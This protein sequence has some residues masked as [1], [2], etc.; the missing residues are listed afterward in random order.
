MFDQL[1]NLE[2]F[3]FNV[4]A[5]PL[6]AVGMLIFI[7]GSSILWQGRKICKNVSFFLLCASF[8][9]WLCSMGI[10]YLCNNV[11]SALLWYK[12]FTFF[13]VVSIMPSGYLFSVAS[14]GLMKK[15]R[16]VV[17]GIYVFSYIIYFFALLTDKIIG[18]SR[19]YFW[20]YY[21]Q[22]KPLS[23]IFIV[24]FVIV[25]TMLQRN[26]WDYY[27]RERIPIKKNQIL[28]IM[29]G[30]MVA[31][32]A[33]T[34]FVPK[35]FDFPLYP[36]GYISLFIFTCL[37]AYSIIRYRAFDIETVFHKT[38]LWI[39]SFM[40]IVIP[41]FLLY[42]KAMPHM[43]HSNLL[44]FGFWTLSFMFFA[45]YLRVVQPK[46]DH[47][48][49][50]RKANLEEISSQFIEGLVHLKGLN[51]LIELIRNT[52]SNSLYPQHIDIFIYNEDKRIYTLLT[53]GNKRIKEIT[54]LK[55]DNEFLQWLKGNNK[56]VYKEFIYID[57]RYRGIGLDA[58]RYFK[59]TGAIV[60][61]PLVVNAKLLGIINLG[62]KA[63]LKRYTADEFHFLN[64]LKNES[65]IAISNSLLY[66]NM[67]SQVR[68]RSKELVEMQKQLVQ[69]EKLATVGTLAGGVAH[70]INNPLTAILTSVQMLLMSD[71]IADESD[72]ESLELIEEA[73]KR[74]RLIVQKL[75]VY[76]RKPMDSADLVKVDFAEVIKNVIN[77]LKYQLEQ[78]NITVITSI[79]DTGYFVEG[80]QNDLEHVVTNIILNGKDAI[81]QVKKSGTISISLKEK[82]DW[83]ILD[84]Q[85]E[86]AGIP[87]DLKNKIFDPFFTTKDVGKGLGLG[88]SICQSIIDRH[89]GL[90]NVE[91]EP[92]QGTV[93]TI[94]LFKAGKG[95]RAR[96]IKQ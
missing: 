71:E 19:L 53:N 10:V 63:N 13:G 22:Y 94:K 54:F 26:L 80:N 57:P 41:V 74:C 2:N 86:G 56:T 44:Q 9:I 79:K 55:E 16:N 58:R 4:H 95:D 82:G 12:V 34:D 85:D 89:N 20:G 84:I 87:A 7:I 78:E 25:F 27:K 45:L 46:V 77:F 11:Q 61:I 60:A 38:I 33:S 59:F 48:F 35:F 72:R 90:I 39:L 15:Q 32:F 75:M 36:F 76:A 70:E 29:T 93:F 17:V 88:L 21:P 73:T 68:Q 65:A 1:F 42:K 6:I 43:R 69:A 18:S 40:L 23:L 5:I 28:I 31:F 50:R 3:T 96:N 51:N 64:T 81:K 92:E 30:F 49:Q 8:T 52:I 47:F 83:L 14:S 24:F 66:D 37:V 91:S 62:K 67:E